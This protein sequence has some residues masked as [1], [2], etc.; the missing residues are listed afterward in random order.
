MLVFNIYAVVVAIFVAILAAPLFWLAPEFMEGT[1]GDVTL[2]SIVL[3]IS[4]LAEIG[5]LKARVFWLPVW[6]WSLAALGYLL[7]GEWGWWGP[8]GAGVVAVT[9]LTL[10]LL[11]SRKLEREEWAKAPQQL[12]L[13]RAIVDNFEAREQCFTHLHEAFFSPTWMSSTAEIWAHQREVLA[14]ADK[15]LDGHTQIG[16]EHLLGMLDRAYAA[17]IEGAEDAEDIDSELESEVEALIEH[18]GHPP[19]DD[20]DDE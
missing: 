16:K 7:Y 10:L 20:D 1:Y 13:A 12:E 15:L 19:D 17:K 6:L 8:A 2:A 9:A 5:G 4:T 18:Q 11:W 14:V 3:L